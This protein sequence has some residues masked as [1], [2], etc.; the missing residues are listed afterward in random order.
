MAVY[1]YNPKQ[2]KIALGTHTVSGYADDSFVT[3]DPAGDGIQTKYGCDGE[4]NRAISTNQS[5]TIKIA[6]LQNSPT[7]QYL[8]A[9]AGK[10]IEDGTGYFSII[11]KDLMGRETYTSDFCFVNKLASKGYGK[12]TT[13]RE[14]E[15]TGINGKFNHE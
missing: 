1:T 3:I 10:D 15:L 6:L 12:G 13:N 7:N 11:I 14:W 4:V 9:M 2:I 5:Q 8:E